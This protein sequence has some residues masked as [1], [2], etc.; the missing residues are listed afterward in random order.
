MSEIQPHN[1]PYLIGHKEAEQIFLN[2]WKNSGLHNSWIISGI[3]GIGKATFAYRIA[4]FLL[5]ADESKKQSYTSLEVAENSPAFRLIANRAHPDLKII[6]RDF[7]DTDKKKIIKAIKEGEALDDEALQE[8]KKS[9]VIK[10]DEV[11][12][13][14]EFL[15]KKSFDGNWRI[16]IIDS[17]D[18]LNVNGANAVLKVLE[19]PPAKS[20][21]LLISHN[22]NK[23]L[24]TIKSRCAKLNLQPLSEAEVASLL[25]RYN[26]ELS[27]AAVQGIAKISAGSIGHGL[28]YAEYGGLDM[29]K[30]LES[31]FYAGKNFDLSQ[32]LD[33]SEKVAKDEELWNLAVELIEHFFIENIKGGEKVEQLSQALQKTR[34]WLRDVINLNMDKKQVMFNIINTVS[35]VL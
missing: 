25:R 13:I 14:N 12:T 26:P 27:E 35:G 28:R 21:L 7:I 34:G 10:V 33:F 15:S 22:P 32:A 1:N 11:R 29:Y 2:A 5:S 31:L 16:V 24:P 3:S 23:L 18:D 17:V 30:T 20:L 8:L 4:R 19:E 9:S 6:E